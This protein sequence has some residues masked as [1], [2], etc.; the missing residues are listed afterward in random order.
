MLLKDNQNS[1]RNEEADW[2]IGESVEGGCEVIMEIRN[3][4]GQAHAKGEKR[5]YE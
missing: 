2:T 1:S 3:T 5:L 4:I